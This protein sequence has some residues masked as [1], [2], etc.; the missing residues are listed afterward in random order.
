MSADL[1]GSETPRLFTPPARPLTPQ[2]SLGFEAIAFAR[3]LL[4][5]ELLPWQEWLFIHALE[6]DTAGAFRFRTVVVLVARQN[7]KTLWAQVLSL[8]RMYVDR[9]GL[10]LGTAQ[11]LELAEEVWSGAVDMAEGVPELAEEIATVER[12]AGKKTLHLKGKQRYKVQ[13]ANRRGGRGLS[14]D[15]VLLD[16]L[17]EHQTWDAWSAVTK[18][19]MARPRP[20]IVCLSNAGDAASIVLNDIRA[21]ALQAIEGRG[22]SSLG[23]FEWSAT[24]DCDVDD[25]TEIARANPSLG[26]TIRP[27]AIKAALATDPEHVFRTEVLCQRVDRSAVSILPAWPDLEDPAT[28]VTIGDRVAF[29][30]DVSWDRATASITVA[31]Q[32]DDGR[33]HLELVAQGEGTA[34]V[35][36]WLSERVPVWNPVGVAVQGTGAPVSSI[37]DDIEAAVGTPLMARVDGQQLGASCAGMFDAVAGGVVVHTNQPQMTDAARFAATRPVGDSW[38][39]DRKKSP[40]DIAPLMAATVALHALRTFKQ[41]ERARKTG[42]VYAF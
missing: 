42:A 22:D 31:A 33:V 5:I 9:A 34:W 11:K 19:T 1:V 28:T 23:I 39:F 7:G 27:E 15:L 14:G 21:K 16:E 38:L 41:P 18:T 6:L 40:V 4:G 30:V 32:R 35:A 17:R 36:K 12:A 29:G 3:D 26:R 37:A 20:Q 24:E 2:T 10:V 13:S 8:W 25:W